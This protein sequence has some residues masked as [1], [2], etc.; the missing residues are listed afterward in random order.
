M[1]SA[2]FSATKF[3]KALDAITDK[4]VEAVARQLLID[5][6]NN[7]PVGKTGKFKNSWR[8]SGKGSKYRITNPQPYGPKLE[9]G[10]S[11]QA[12]NGVM[13]PAIRNYN[14]TLRRYER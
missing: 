1:S 12:P 10:K 7:S 9:Q 13:A 11:K 6:K 4:V 2:T 8:L 3:I 5:V 14:P